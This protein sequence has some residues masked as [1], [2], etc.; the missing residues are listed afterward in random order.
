MDL[1]QGVSTYSLCV[2]ASVQE[3]AL[4]KWASDETS[5]FL[6][7]L[8]DGR[9]PR[10]S[11]FPEGDND[12]TRCLH[13]D[14]HSVQMFF[15]ATL[16]GLCQVLTLGPIT[17][18]ATVT[19]CK[20]GPWATGGHGSGFNLEMLTGKELRSSIMGKNILWILILLAVS[21]EKIRNLCFLP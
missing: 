11:I 5:L 8:Q 1:T 10:R 2:P 19:S 7:G 21:N 20:A 16:L 9:G 3:K 17:C 18:N 14:L 4:H 15:P 13:L 6:L 12:E